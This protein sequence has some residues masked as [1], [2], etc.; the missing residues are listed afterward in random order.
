[1][2]F[3]AANSL[4]YVWAMYAGGGSWL[5]DQQAH[6]WNHYS[7]SGRQLTRAEKCSTSAFTLSPDADTLLNHADSA[8]AVSLHDGKPAV[9]QIDNFFTA[10]D[11]AEIIQVSRAAKRAPT[12]QFGRT[13]GVVWLAHNASLVVQ[14]IVSSVAQTLNIPA[15]HAEALQVAWYGAGDGYRLHFDAFDD[16]RSLVTTKSA[17]M[18]VPNRVI[19]ALGYLNTMPDGVGF[20]VFPELGLKIQ[21]KL[22]RLLLF[23]NLDPEYRRYNSSTHM[24]ADLPQNDGVSRKWVFNLFFSSHPQGTQLSCDAL[25]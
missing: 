21:P 25:L 14:S 19:T 10:A 1:M 6:E 12:A 5:W 17:A 24:A 15:T 9:L 4:W 23:S 3:A 22:G 18:L 11:S 20:T 7:E 8:M 16:P 13:G 2:L